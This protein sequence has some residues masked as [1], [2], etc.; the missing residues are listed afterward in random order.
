MIPFQRP[1]F[2]STWI[3]KCL[4]GILLTGLLAGIFLPL[5]P[6]QALT[7]WSVYAVV[8][9]VILVVLIVAGIVEKCY[10]FSAQLFVVLALM[11]MVYFKILLPNLH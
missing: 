9:T 7:Y 4:W 3:G 1:R 8:A 6:D 2:L 5:R 11:A 10:G